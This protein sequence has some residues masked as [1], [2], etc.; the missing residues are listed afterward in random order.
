MTVNLEANPG[1]TWDDA[2]Q[3]FNDI[4][5]KYFKGQMLVAIKIYDGEEVPTFGPLSRVTSD[6]SQGRMGFFDVGFLSDSECVRL[7]KLTSQKLKNA[8]WTEDGVDV[9]GTIVS[10]LGMPVDEIFAM[11]KVRIFQTIQLNLTEFLLSEEKNL[12]PEQGKELFNLASA[13]DVANRVDGMKGVGR[14]RLPT[15]AALQDKADKIIRLREEKEK[16]NAAKAED[17]ND[18]DKPAS[19][20]DSQ[21]SDESGCSEKPVAKRRDAP[22]IDFGTALAAKMQAAPK[23]KL[24]HKSIT[25]AS[26]GRSPSPGSDGGSLKST[27][28]ASSSGDIP[29]IEKLDSE[30]AKV[31]RKLGLVPPCFEALSLPDTLLGKKNGRGRDSAMALRKL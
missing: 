29:G 19:D 17:G 16:G 21:N 26:L 15:L 12:R 13:R 30:M 8:T 18:A 27:M 1:L 7:T 23:R 24:V 11:R 5:E 25:R 10:L 2:V 4:A 28:Q 14:L 22:T 6:Q 20:D 31:A 9:K 3:K